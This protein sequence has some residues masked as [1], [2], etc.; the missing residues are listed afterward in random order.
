ALAPEDEARTAVAYAASQDWHSALALVPRGNWG[1]RVLDAFRD[2]FSERGGE[3]IDYASFNTSHYDHRQ[4]VQNVLRGFHN[5]AAIDFIFIAARP[6][7]ARLLRSQLR[8]YQAAEL[9]VV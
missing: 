9:P 1:G 5:G 6:A 8:F 4:A 3:L 2:A 7:H